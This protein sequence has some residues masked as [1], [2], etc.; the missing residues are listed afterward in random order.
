MNDM[1][2]RTVQNVMTE[3]DNS[4]LTKLPSSDEVKNVVFSMN[5]DGAPGPNG[6]G[7]YFYKNKKN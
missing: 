7:G 2:E 5:G 4:M 3:E 1:V 6:F